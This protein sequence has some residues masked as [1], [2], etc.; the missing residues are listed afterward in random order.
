ME[1]FPVTRIAHIRTDNPTPAWLVDELW[2]DQA[3]GFI[4]GT[5]KSAKTWLAL[6]LAVAVASGQPCLGRYPVRQRGHVLLYAAEDTA[7]AI[8]HR[9]IGIAK[10]RGIP[11]IERLAVGLIIEHQLRLDAPKHQER[12][13]ATVHK[14]R[15]R[16]LILDPLVRLHRS[17]ENS[18]ADISLLLDFLR[19]IQRRHACAVVLV[20]HVRKSPAGQ[21]GQALRGSGD[22]HAWSD[23]SLYLLRRNGSLQLHAEHRSLQSPDPVA[24]ELMTD[25]CPHLC[26]TGNAE[27]DEED[28]LP[29]RILAALTPRPM[30][31][32][33]LREILGVRN[34]RLGKALGTLE[35]AGR[36]RKYDG[37][38]AVPV[39]SRQ[40]A[41]A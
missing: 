21:P 31:R 37:L 22:L 3:V 32:T 18:S 2:A 30:N 5:P 35:A 12:L 20:H 25:P 33:A 15:P 10:A 9:T 41:A 1:P 34:E 24:V 7:A 11:D 38:L 14:L 4:A 16:L 39:P 36:I 27:K 19:Q 40:D 28:P 13:D 29:A 6:E 17:D 23:S 26:V 8:K